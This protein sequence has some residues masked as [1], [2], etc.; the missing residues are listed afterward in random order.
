MIY[1]AQSGHIGGSFSIA[2]TIAY[3]FNNYKFVND[4]QHDILILSKGHAAPI[5]YAALY[6]D[7]KIDENELKTFREINSRLEGHPV[8]N[9]IPEVFATTGSLGQGLSIAVGHAIAKKML[10]LS[11]KVFCI[12]G[13]GELQEGQIWETLV[14]LNSYPLD[15]L[16]ILLDNN[17]AQNDG[18]TKQFKN[19]NYILREFN[20]EWSELNGNDIKELEYITNMNNNKTKFIT[21]Q[22]IKGYGVSFMQTPEWHGKIP[23]KDEYERAMNELS[24]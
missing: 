18:L 23:N 21:L 5:L 10:N 1:N 3:L 13:D 14:F 8:K 7:N 20:F 12:I 22:T 19:L 24:N 4:K 6:L 17:G 9:K 16:Y 2:E 15:N 11:G